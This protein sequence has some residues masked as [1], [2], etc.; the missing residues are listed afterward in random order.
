MNEIQLDDRRPFGLEK[1]ELREIK[2]LGLKTKVFTP[3]H[4]SEIIVEGTE[5]VSH[6]IDMFR[7]E[8]AQFFKSHSHSIVGFDIEEMSKIAN[9]VCA[10][11]NKGNKQPKRAQFSICAMGLNITPKLKA[12]VTP[13]TLKGPP[14]IAQNTRFEQDILKWIHHQGE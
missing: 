3:K 12:S 4:L 2:D 8:F 6:H 14:S 1:D 10:T 13:V 9:P 5:L 11:E 7:K